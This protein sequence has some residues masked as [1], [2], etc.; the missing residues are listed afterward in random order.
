MKPFQTVF[1]HQRNKDLSFEKIII[2]WEESMEK[3]C[4]LRKKYSF[5]FLN[6]QKT[7]RTFSLIFISIVTS[8]TH[9]NRIVHYYSHPL[10]MTNIAHRAQT[11]FNVI[12]NLCLRNCPS[13][14][15]KLS[16]KTLMRTNGL[17]ARFKN[18]FKRAIVLAFSW[19][20]IPHNK[21]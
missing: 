2:A 7:G 16:I 14:I 6:A 5:I 21:Y 15:Y 4:I 8:L 20:A 3:Q 12:Y 13:R 17:K 10:L 18:I 11:I 1:Y 9:G 19:S